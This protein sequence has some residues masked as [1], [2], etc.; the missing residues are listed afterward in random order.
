MLAAL[1]MAYLLGGGGGVAGSVLTPGAVKHIGK[2]VERAVADSARADLATQALAELKAEVKAFEKKFGK[3]GKQL[4]KLYKEHGAEAE[5]MLAVLDGLNGD[6]ESAQQRA[7]ELRF[8]LKESLTEAE[9]G[10][11]FGDKGEE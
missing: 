10:E 8:E 9:W 1:L 3:S 7:V 2:D 11:V 4:T 6:W 5:Q